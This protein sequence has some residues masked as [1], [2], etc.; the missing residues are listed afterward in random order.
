MFKSATPEARAIGLFADEWKATTTFVHQSLK[1]KTAQLPVRIREEFKQANDAADSKKV[2][3]SSVAS[4]STTWTGATNADSLDVVTV[5]VSSDKGKR[6][7]SFKPKVSI[8]KHAE[9]HGAT[10]SVAEKK[11]RGDFGAVVC[12]ASPEAFFS[13]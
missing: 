2:N 6:N 9:G 13:I 12:S 11:R 7:A 4:S 10:P 8:K 1:I 5:S 3:A